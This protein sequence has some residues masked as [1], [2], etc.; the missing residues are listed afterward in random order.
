MV[1]LVSPLNWSHLQ[2]RI[3][4]QWLTSVYTLSIELYTG[5]L[6]TFM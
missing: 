2:S 4:Y 6:F 5:N 1:S 3:L